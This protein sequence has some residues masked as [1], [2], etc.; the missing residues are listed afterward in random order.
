VGLQLCILGW[1]GAG[2]VAA[3]VHPFVAGDPGL[4]AALGTSLLAAVAVLFARL[5][6]GERFAIAAWLV[7][8][9]LIAM[10]IKLLLVD[11]PHGRPLTHFLSLAALGAALLVA[12][13][14]ARRAAGAGRGGDAAPSA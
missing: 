7:Y 10:A 9:L 14:A 5:G 11:V 3:A 4:R 13:R 8:P 12:A 2:V 6:G 1:I